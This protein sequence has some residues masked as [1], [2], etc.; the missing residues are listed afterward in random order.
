MDYS[1]ERDR[2]TFDVNGRIDTTML[3]MTNLAQ[4]ATRWPVVKP[5]LIEPFLS[6]LRKR[7]EERGFT[8]DE[9]FQSPVAY[10]DGWYQF[11]WKEYRAASLP[12]MTANPLWPGWKAGWETAW[13][14]TKLET[15]Y[16]TIVDGRLS[17]STNSPGRRILD[18]KPGVYMMSDN[19]KNKAINY[20]RS[21]SLQDDGTAY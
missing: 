16:K 2:G 17:A 4:L 5:A 7:K 1:L 20:A 3:S 6:F 8:L 10:A 13:H 18:G 14:G 15:V 11:K 9:L 19:T 12:T 21:V